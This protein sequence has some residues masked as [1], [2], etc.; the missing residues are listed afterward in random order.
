MW[1]SHILQDL[2]V[3]INFQIDLYCDNQSTLSIAHN[4][5]L[6]GRTMHI[7]IDIH[8]IHDYIE[9]GFLKPIYISTL[10]QVAEAFTKFLGI[11]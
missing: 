1:L 6:H 8:I 11:V 7:D 5:C 4:P 2:D 3:Q 9:S 10:Q